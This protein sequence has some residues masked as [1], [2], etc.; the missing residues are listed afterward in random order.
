MVKSVLNK[1]VIKMPQYLA[2]TGKSLLAVS[3]LHIFY[4]FEMKGEYSPH[5][6]LH[7]SEVA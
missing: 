2:G 3:K 5:Q 1:N 7:A 6:L 4:S